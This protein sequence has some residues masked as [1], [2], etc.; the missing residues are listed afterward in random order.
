MYCHTGLCV[1]RKCVCDCVSCLYKIGHVIVHLYCRKA[2]DAERRSPFSQSVSLPPPASLAPTPNLPPALSGDPVQDQ[3]SVLTLQQRTLTF[4]AWNKNLLCL[5]E[6]WTCNRFTA[7]MRVL[8]MI[9]E[10]DGNLNLIFDCM[11][12]CFTSFIITNLFLSL[13]FV[14]MY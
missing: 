12:C 13:Q 3:L 1:E 10:N 11:F 9:F 5:P 2:P 14:F 6:I 4:L 7:L 8:G